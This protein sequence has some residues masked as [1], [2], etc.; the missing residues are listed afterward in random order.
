M[1]PHGSSLSQIALVGGKMT[2]GNAFGEPC[3]PYWING[4]GQWRSL[5]AA[6]YLSKRRAAVGKTKRGKGTKVML[7][8]D[9]NGLSIGL[10]FASTSPH[11]EKLAVPTSEAVQVPRRIGGRPKSSVLRGWLPTGR[12]TASPSGA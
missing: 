4:G 9:G 1:V 5:T 10:L 6:L 8:T 7:V 2:L 11:E 3:S 12:T